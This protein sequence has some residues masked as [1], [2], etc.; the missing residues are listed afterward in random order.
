MKILYSTALLF[1]LFAFSRIKINT[2][3]YFYTEN[4]ILKLALH[5]SHSFIHSFPINY[6]STNRF[7][8]Q[9]VFIQI[10][11]ILSINQI[12]MFFFKKKKPTTYY[13]DI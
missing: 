11:N 9:S 7:S 3:I 8:S 1:P 5:F 12:K 13:R 2:V 10:P 4:S 6:N